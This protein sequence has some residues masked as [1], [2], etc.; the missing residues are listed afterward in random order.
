MFRRSL[1]AGEGVLLVQSRD[2]RMDSAIHMLFMWIDLAVVWITDAGEVVDVKL[3][4][5]WRPAYVPKRPARY[6]LE[7]PTAHL[8]DFQIGDKIKFEEAWLD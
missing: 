6:V 8:N 4:R 3:A 2:T 1:P 5:R 7:V